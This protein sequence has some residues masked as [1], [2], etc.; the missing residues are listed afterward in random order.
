MYQGNLGVVAING[1]HTHMED[2]QIRIPEERFSTKILDNKV[3]WVVPVLF[4]DARS[5]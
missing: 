1:S 5:G 3:Y 4:D 2:I